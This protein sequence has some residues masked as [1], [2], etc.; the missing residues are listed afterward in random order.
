MKKKQLMVAIKYCLICVILNSCVICK[1]KNNIK[2]KKSYIISSSLAN[3]ERY[4]ISVPID[5]VPQQSDGQGMMFNEKR[6][7]IVLYGIN[8]FE[9]L[10]Q[11]RGYDLATFSGV[12]LNTFIS[13][14]SFYLNVHEYEQVKSY[15]ILAEDAEKSMRLNMH[16]LLNKNSSGELNKYFLDENYQPTYKNRCIIHNLFHNGICAMLNDEIGQIVFW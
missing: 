11:N 14:R 5:T 10:D 1:D 12:L 9:A 16:K 4:L 15:I 8:L 7:Y 13:N 6:Q 2:V 3:L